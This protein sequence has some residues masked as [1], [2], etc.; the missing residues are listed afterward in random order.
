MKM[1]NEKTVP[2]AR[3]CEVLTLAPR[4]RKIFIESL[5]VPPIPNQKAI[6]A[7]KR[8]SREV[9]LPLRSASARDIL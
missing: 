3:E 8:S 4:S 7:A 5:L 2:D 1:V 9:T 6:A